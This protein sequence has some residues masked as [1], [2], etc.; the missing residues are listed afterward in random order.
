MQM[1]TSDSLSFIRTRINLLPISIKN[2]NLKIKVC[3]SFKRIVLE[4]NNTISIFVGDYKISF[5]K[6]YACFSQD[7]NTL[8]FSLQKHYLLRCREIQ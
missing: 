5:H 7:F 6:V 4:A 1:S 2:L 8:F 3:S